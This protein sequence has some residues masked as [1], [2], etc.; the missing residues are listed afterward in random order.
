MQVPQSGTFL[1]SLCIH[2][3][4]TNTIS[5]YALLN[6]LH[7]FNQRLSYTYVTTLYL[8]KEIDT[9]ITIYDWLM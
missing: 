6:E 9:F 8:H 2:L 4:I 5:Y 7:K 1:L 3:G